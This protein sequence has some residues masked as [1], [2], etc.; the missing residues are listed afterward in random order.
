M[1]NHHV[2]FNTAGCGYDDFSMLIDRINMAIAKNKTQSKGHELRATTEVSPERKRAVKALYAAK[3]TTASIESDADWDACGRSL[4]IYSLPT[5]K[6]FGHCERAT[7]IWKWDDEA[8]G[9][10]GFNTAAVREATSS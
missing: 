5:Y 6:E 4:A 2:T 1:Q 9:A 8:L 10:T 3:D 7:G